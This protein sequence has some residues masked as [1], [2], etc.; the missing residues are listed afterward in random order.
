MRSDPRRSL[1][2]AQATIPGRIAPRAACSC[3]DRRRPPADRLPTGKGG[4]SALRLTVPIRATIAAAFRLGLIP[5][6]G[7]EPVA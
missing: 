5:A 4:L 2:R 6:R 7:T 1:F 3:L